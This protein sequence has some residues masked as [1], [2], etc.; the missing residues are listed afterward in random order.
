MKTYKDYTKRT[1]GESDIATLV[2]VGMGEDEV[3]SHILNYQGDETYS[4]YIIKRKENESVS[5][6][7]H[8]ELVSS[9]TNWIRIYDDFGKSAEYDGKVINIYRAGGYSTIVEIIE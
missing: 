6:A 2:L 8:Y 9:F 4:A 3:K 7:D 1:I 5:I